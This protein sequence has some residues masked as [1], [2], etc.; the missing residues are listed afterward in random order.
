LAHTLKGVA[1]NIGAIDLQAAAGGLELACGTSGG[2]PDRSK[3]L[4][5]VSAELKTVLDGLSVLSERSTEVL[6]GGVSVDFD[7]LLPL[8]ERLE[9][10]LKQSDARAAQTAVGIG[11]LLHGCRHAACFE[12]ISSVVNPLE[13]DLA[14]KQLRL[15]RDEMES[16]PRPARLPSCLAARAPPSFPLSTIFP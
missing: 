7:K 13:F 6:Q 10:L 2:V 1:G 3:A 14:A 4:A 15:M 8:F 12:T 16:Q 5:V 11:A 9:R